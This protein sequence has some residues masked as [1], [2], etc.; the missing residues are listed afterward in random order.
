MLFKFFLEAVL[1]EQICGLVH[2]AVIDDR[3]HIMADDL[4]ISFKTIY[5]INTMH[6]ADNAQ[7]QKNTENTQYEM[8]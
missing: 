8:H 6:M 1:L 7:F 3:I 4:Q 5:I 2:Q